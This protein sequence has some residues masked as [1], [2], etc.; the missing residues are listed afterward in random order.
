M[1]GMQVLLQFPQ[2]NREQDPA[3]PGRMLLSRGTTWFSALHAHAQRPPSILVSSDVATS[4]TFAAVAAE[5]EEPGGPA[6]LWHPVAI[7]S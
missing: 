6:L 4:P 2:V 5:G 3:T 7:H 1:K